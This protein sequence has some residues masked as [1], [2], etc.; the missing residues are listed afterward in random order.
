MRR[1]SFCLPLVIIV[2]LVSPISLAQGPIATSLRAAVVDQFFTAPSALSPVAPTD[3]TPC[4]DPL[5][6]TTTAGSSGGGT[7][8]SALLDNYTFYEI[9]DIVVTVAVGAPPAAQ[10]GDGT[11]STTG[12]AIN[13]T[14][15]IG[16]DATVWDSQEWVYTGTTPTTTTPPAPHAFTFTKRSGDNL[17]AFP[18]GSAL[19]VV[20]ELRSAP[21]AGTPPQLENANQNA[22]LECSDRSKVTG[23]DIVRG[24]PGD[25]DI[26]GDGVPPTPDPDDDEDGFDDDVERR[27]NCTVQEARFDFSTNAE[28]RPG[29]H[30]GD[31]DGQT[32]EQECKDGYSPINQ[33]DVKPP[34][35]PFPLMQVILAGVLVL[36]VA[37]I[38]LFFLKL[39]KAAAV[40]VL[41][42][43]AIIVPPG[44]AGRFELEVK[45]IRNKGNSINF[46]LAAGGYPDGWDAKITPDHVVLDPQGGTKPSEKVWLTVESPN[47]TDAESAVVNV[48][49]VPLNAAGRKDST[50]LPASAKAITSINVPPNAKVPVKRGALV[51]TLTDAE[52]AKEAAAAT[53][54]AAEE[55]PATKKRGKKAAEETPAPEPAPA[56]APAKPAIQ[57]GGLSHK[58]PSFH[59]GEAVKSSVTVTNNGEA[60]QTIKLNLFINDALADAQTASLKPG[61]SKEITFKWTAQERN[62][63]NI[64]GELLP[65]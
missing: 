17:T 6:S 8:T 52:M 3:R 21:P 11:F 49:A 46:Q 18:N 58:P 55:A 23:F 54:A 15:S 32:D 44:T 42:S 1:L 25:Q 45:N 31:G 14:M 5:T 36:V 38:V 65:S 29:N 39:G 7:F 13:V 59:P 60:P 57:V 56:P 61:K 9:E 20:V 62:K 35:K 22:Q 64:R 41:S 19:R 30:D 28:L 26:D 27:I 2:L 47:H 53:P 24:N 33:Q 34:P 12:L 50:K 51:K 37:F 43:P 40:T 10:G 16:T 63:L 4:G 48:K